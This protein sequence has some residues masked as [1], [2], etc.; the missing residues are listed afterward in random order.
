MAKISSLELRTPTAAL[1]RAACEV[2]DQD[3]PVVEPALTELFG[4][5]PDN[6]D[7]R[8]VLLKVVAL[9][10]LYSTR[11]PIYSEK[12]PNA[13]DLAQHIHKNAQEIDSGLAVD[14]PG[15]VETIAWVRAAGKKERGYFSFATK[16][17]SWHRPELYPMW[18]AN[19]QTYIE[20]LQ[21]RSDFAKPFNVSADHWKYKEFRGAMNAFRDRYHLGSFA[22]KDI[23]KFLWLEGGRLRSSGSQ[24]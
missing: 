23:D 4:R 10:S 7:V 24:T 5:Y 15:I 11:I 16:Y 3:N 22:F 12:I 19:V 6:K 9:N 20:Y 14:A 17:C 1:V 8:H 13:V 21:E 18:D 2:F